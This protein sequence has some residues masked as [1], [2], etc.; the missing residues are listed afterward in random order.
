M[1]SPLSQILIFAIGGALFISVTLLVSRLIRPNRPSEAKLM[2]YESGEA[3]QG[4]AWIQFNM[5][6]YVLALIFLLFE[7]EIVFL[8]PWSTVFA[9][10]NL[11][12]QTNGAWAWFAFT[13]M[14]IFILILVVGLIY[15]WKKGHLDWV[16]SKPVVTDYKSPVP[17]DFYKQINSKYEGVSHPKKDV[18][19]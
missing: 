17:M 1:L 16:K 11:N 14:L 12:A 4:I 10:S 5:R 19:E 7:V 18:A 6:F 13:E 2:T 15:V 9:N 3:P 8:F